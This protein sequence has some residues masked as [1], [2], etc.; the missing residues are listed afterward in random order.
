MIQTIDRK[1]LEVV[2]D[3]ESNIDSRIGF[4]GLAFATL[5]ISLFI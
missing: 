5:S 2:N 3:L 4:V 1:F